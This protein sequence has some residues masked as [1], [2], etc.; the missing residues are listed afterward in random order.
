[1]ADLGECMASDLRFEEG[2]SIVYQL[3]E[4]NKLKGR[5]RR[6]K[7]RQ[8]KEK[9]CDSLNFPPKRDASCVL[10]IKN[11]LDFETETGNITFLLI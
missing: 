11:D 5:E 7:N 1:M 3:E 4:K 6:E 8:I 10:K 2:C 9:R